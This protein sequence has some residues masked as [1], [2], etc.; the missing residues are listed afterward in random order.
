MAGSH[1]LSLSPQRLASPE[2]SG[3]VVVD[4]ANFRA[5]CA[6]L[7]QEC[8]YLHDNNCRNEA[9]WN[10]A[11]AALDDEPAPLPEAVLDAFR[12]S[13]RSCRRALAAAL[14][15]IAEQSEYADVNIDETVCVVRADHIYT[16]AAELELHPDSAEAKE[17]D[18]GFAVLERARAALA[19]SEGE[20]G[21]P[22]QSIEWVVNSLG[23]LGVCLSGRYFFLYKGRSIEY[24]GEDAEGVMVRPVGKREFG[25]V[26]R[27]LDCLKVENGILYDRTPRPYVQELLYAPGLSDGQP[28]DCD[29]RPLPGHRCG[30]GPADTAS[31]APAPALVPVAVS[32]WPWERHGWS[33]QDGR[34]WIFLNPDNGW[35]IPRWILSRPMDYD[36]SVSTNM[37]YSLPHYAIPLPQAGEVEA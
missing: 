32:E 37:A 22:K 18:A 14:R 5:L 10:R 3:V 30:H 19:Q 26:C 28:G 35:T 8:Q 31:S 33:D 6:E 4:H 2:C 20:A 17:L 34:C 7:L 27:P 36:F 12:F 13:S 24:E 16:I 9:L 25:E 11:R 21:R 29:W 23:E 1:A 15:A